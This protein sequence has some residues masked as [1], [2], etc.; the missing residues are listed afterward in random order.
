[1]VSV[2][3]TSFA[4]ATSTSPKLG[5]EGVSTGYRSIGGFGGAEAQRAPR[6]QFKLGSLLGTLKGHRFH[7]DGR[8]TRPAPSVT[9]ARDRKHHP[10]A[11]GPG[12]FLFQAAHYLQDWRLPPTHQASFSPLTQRIATS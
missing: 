2:K 4:S 3:P 1:M 7:P 5:K 6:R 9:W 8:L 12:R 11:L 10:L